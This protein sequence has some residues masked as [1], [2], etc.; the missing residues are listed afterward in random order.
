[1]RLRRHGERLTY[2]PARGVLRRPHCR[3]THSDPRCGSYE[4]TL[5]LAASSADASAY[6]K[7]LQTLTDDK[8]AETL[9]NALMSKPQDRA[10]VEA[11]RSPEMLRR[12]EGALNFLLREVHAWIK[13]RTSDDPTISE[14]RRR[15]EHYRNV[16]SRE[17]AHITAILTAEDA[18]KGVIR[19]A[20]N[21]RRRAADR[22]VQLNLAGDVSQGTYQRLLEEEQKYDVELRRK[23]KNDTQVRATKAQMK[24]Q[25]AKR[26]E[27]R[28]TDPPV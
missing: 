3:P 5:A 18:R 11:F 20:P 17:R 7:T 23:A 12:S 9:A 13:R 24:V 6:V 8:F 1:M 26:R 27:K 28:R 4:R 25:R 2:D 10:L 22:L 14:Q 19:R 16:L 15:T 21:A